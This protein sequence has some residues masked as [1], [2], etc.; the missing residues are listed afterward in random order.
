MNELHLLKTLLPEL[1]V[2]ASVPVGPGDDCAVLDGGGG[3]RLLAAVDQL[4]GD[5]HYYA[6]RTAPEAAGAKLLKRNLSDIAAMGGTPRWALLTLAAGGRDD[7]WLLR[8]A[9]AVAREAAAYGVLLVGGDLA[10]L[11]RTCRGEVATLTILGAPAADQALLLRRN[12]VP[13]ED[14]W[15]TGTLGNS[16]ES[17]H[18]LN[19]RPRLE[20]GRFLAE[21][22]FSRCALD[23]SDGL[24]LDAARLAEASGVCVEIDAALLPLRRNASPRN[25]LCDGE[26]YELLFTVS[27][28]RSPA[29]AAAWPE[30]FAPVTRIG[31]I[32]A[33]GN[34]L[35]VCDPEG[36]DWMKQERT[37]YVHQ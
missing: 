37:G 6:D 8:F 26:D 3:E 31:R 9:R 22:G 17:G 10:A 27:P 25:A 30:H 21:H 29:L 4:I 16:L 1:P 2:D 33:A 18:H 7:D 28:D 19:F 11:P 20:E 5:V 34:G 36:N 15:V 24:L 35:K 12:A 32:L 23:L 13:G 14:L